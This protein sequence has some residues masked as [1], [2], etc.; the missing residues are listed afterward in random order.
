M[1]LVAL[2]IKMYL[3]PL[4]AIIRDIYLTI[5]C[6][7]FYS[8]YDVANTAINM[9]IMYTSI[10]SVSVYTYLYHSRTVYI[11]RRAGLNFQYPEVGQYVIFNDPP[12]H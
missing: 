11:N 9:P 2:K 10:P 4:L 3:R 1:T 6:A 12:F 5:L 7:Y 8:A